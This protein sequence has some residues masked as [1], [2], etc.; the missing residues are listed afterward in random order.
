MKTLKPPELMQYPNR[1]RI[2]RQERKWTLDDVAQF[3]GLTVP[4]VSRHES[5][6]RS[7][8]GPLIDRYAT[9]Y[10]VSPFEI[11]VGNGDRIIRKR[12][13]ETES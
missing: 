3:M 9:L 7:L 4:A 11:F 13:V 8:D 2:L 10:S 1:L 5:G 6:N 12:T